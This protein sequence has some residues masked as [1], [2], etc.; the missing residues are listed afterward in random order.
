MRELV[1]KLNSQGKRVNV[2]AKC[3]V[4]TLKVGEGLA[5]GTA[6][7]ANAFAHQYNATGGWSNGVLILEEI[8]TLETGLLHVISARK[9]M[10]VQFIVLGDV[11]QHPA[12]GDSFGGMPCDEANVVAR[13]GADRGHRM[14]ICVSN[15]FAG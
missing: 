9:K 12:I 1:R 5:E 13:G 2:I 6:M 7:T 15:S 8:M 10:G 3:H 14:S 4:A 11:N